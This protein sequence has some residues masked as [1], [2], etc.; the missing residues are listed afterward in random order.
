MFLF[1]TDIVDEN[2]ILMVDPYQRQMYQLDTSK[3]HQTLQGL[4]IPTSQFPTVIDIDIVD[5]NIIWLDNAD[6]VIMKAPLIVTDASVTTSRRRRAVKEELVHVV[7][8]GM[9]NRS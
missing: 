6:K 1:M 8:E 5:R 2:F 3:V 9:Q 7:S 4:E